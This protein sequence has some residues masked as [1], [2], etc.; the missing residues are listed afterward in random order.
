MRRHL[1]LALLVVAACAKTD[2]AADTVAAATPAPPPPPVA[3]TA[4]D[5]A[6]TW[7]MKSMPMDKDTV[8]ATTEMMATA[9]TDGWTMKVPGNAKPIAITSVAIAGDSVVTQSAQFNSVLRKGQKVSVHTISHLKDGQLT[10]VVH[11]KYANGDT[12]TLRTTGTKK[13]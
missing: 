9:T 1:V 4:A 12:A 13:P 6:G 3:I 5:L 8:V 11:A 7:E 2:K 10:G